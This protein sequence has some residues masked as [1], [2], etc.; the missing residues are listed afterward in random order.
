MATIAETFVT[1]KLATAETSDF[2]YSTLHGI[3]PKG[4]DVLVVYSR[5]WA[6]GWGVLHWPLVERMLSRFYEYEP[7]MTAAQVNEHFGLVQK[8]RWEQRGQWIE[9]FAALR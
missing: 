2:R 5:T 7:Q 4:V 6:P 1:K 8:R 3:A 9:V